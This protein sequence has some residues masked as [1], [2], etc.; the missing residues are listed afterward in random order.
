MVL[1]AALHVQ[2]GDFRDWHAIDAWAGEIAN[3]LQ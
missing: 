1:M 3:A 2:E